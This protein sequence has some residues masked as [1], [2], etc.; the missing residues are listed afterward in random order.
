V[1]VISGRA[2]D[3]VAACLGL[4]PGPEIQARIGLSASAAAMKEIHSHD[5]ALEALVSAETQLDALHDSKRQRKRFG[6]RL[7]NIGPERSALKLVVYSKVGLS[8]NVARL[9]LQ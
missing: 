4:N 7:S 3:E 1:I 6:S 5:D 8:R 2:D 9:T